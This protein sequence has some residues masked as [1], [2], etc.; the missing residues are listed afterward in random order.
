MQHKQITH[1]TAKIGTHMH[2]HL[3]L[4]FHV[5]PS[6]RSVLQFRWSHL[7]VLRHRVVPQGHLKETG[8]DW[9]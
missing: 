6:E 7:Q 8:L 4:P 5:V 2:V 3:M 9:K 1:K